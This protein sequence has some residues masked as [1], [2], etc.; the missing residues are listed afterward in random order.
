MFV[1]KKIQSNDIA[2]VTQRI[3]WMSGVVYD[4]Y[5]DDIDMFSKD[6]NGFLKYGRD[7]LNI[8]FDS[9]LANLMAEKMDELGL[10]H[11]A[12]GLYS[13][14]NRIEPTNINC[15]NNLG[16]MYLLLL[17]QLDSIERSMNETYFRSLE[18]S[19]KMN[20][21]RKK[22]LIL[23][24]IIFNNLYNWN[25][26]EKEVFERATVWYKHFPKDSKL[27][28]IVDRLNRTNKVEVL[29]KWLFRYTDHIG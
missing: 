15:L 29:R 13:A 4:Y 25:L 1:V 5:R 28:S 16:N 26:T 19:T 9:F 18:M 27:V 10:Y 20:E 11:E 7:A 8:E 23:S 14:I 24:N 6:V 22:E 2:I 12:I 21:H 17:S 3:D